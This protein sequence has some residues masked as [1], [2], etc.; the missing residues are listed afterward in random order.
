M[1]IHVFLPPFIF[2]EKQFGNGMTG[3]NP[4]SL[5]SNLVIEKLASD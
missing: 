1:D 5:E 3:D 2:T 4:L